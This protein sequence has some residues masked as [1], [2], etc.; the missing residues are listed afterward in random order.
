[1]FTTT[2][3]AEE[4]AL[5]GATLDPYRNARQIGYSRIAPGFMRVTGVQC[6]DSRIPDD[7]PR[8][9]L[10]DMPFD[11]IVPERVTREDLLKVIYIQ[12]Q[13]LA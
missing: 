12:S 5:L 3:A 9:R 10:H 13:R 1:M 7:Q 4:L 8:K 11:V 6:D 2:N